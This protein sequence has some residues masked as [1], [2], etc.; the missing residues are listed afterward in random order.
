MRLIYVSRTGDNIFSSFYGFLD[1]SFK[2][3][4]S[5]A[6][7]GEHFSNLLFLKNVFWGGDDSGSCGLRTML[8]G[9]VVFDANIELD[10]V[11]RKVAT[12]F[13]SI[14]DL[15]FCKWN[16]IVDV[17]LISAGGLRLGCQ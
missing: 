8:P 7:L 4:E 11:L 15:K 1:F 12:A 3:I 5:R 13:P 2:L 6:R 9:A 16:K 14:K 17:R 10:R